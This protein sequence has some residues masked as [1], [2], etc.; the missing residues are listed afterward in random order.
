MIMKDFIGFNSLIGKLKH[1]PRSG[2]VRSGVS[3][4]ETVAAHSWRVAVLILEFADEIRSMGADV[5]RAVKMALYHDLGESVIGDLIVMHKYAQIS[6][7]DKY[8]KES[9]AVKGLADESGMAEIYDLWSEM[10]DGQ[11]ATALVVRDFDIIDMLLQAYEYLQKYPDFEILK[12]FME[13]NIA[14]VKTELGQRLLAEIK[15]AQDEFLADK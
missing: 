3:N 4:P 13:N 9:V 2:W 11:S 7:Q 15:S 8:T 14:Q 12:E 6:V 5:N 1:L 10:E